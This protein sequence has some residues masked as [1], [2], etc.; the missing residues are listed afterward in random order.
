MYYLREL[1]SYLSNSYYFIASKNFSLWVSYTRGLFFALLKIRKLNRPIEISIQGYNILVPNNF[2][3]MLML[4]E[5]FVYG[6]YDR[7][8]NLNHVLDL[9][10]YVGDSAIFLSQY[11][12][13]VTMV[14]SDPNNFK[15]AEK[16]CKSLKN[17]ELISWAIVASK[18]EKMYI[19]DDNEYRGTIQSKANEKNKNKMIEVNLVEI[20][21][22]EAKYA[23][24]GLKMDIEWGEYEIIKYWIKNKKFT[25]TRWFIEF[26]FTD[27]Q[28]EDEMKLLKEFLHFIA[29]YKCF[30]YLYDNSSQCVPIIEILNDSEIK[31]INLYFE[32]DSD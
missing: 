7:L 22:L 24:D 14:E 17:V 19:L 26:H 29:W 28:R 1:K 4:G 25:F 2:V 16:N 15:L 8:K 30:Y 20:A 12:S 21:E 31:F 5:I 6:V 13:K 11:N 18:K 23:F 27:S 3:S 9:G 10:G 32:K